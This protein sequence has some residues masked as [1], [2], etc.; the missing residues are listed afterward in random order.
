MTKLSVLAVCHINTIEKNVG[1]ILK[2]VDDI[3]EDL[4]NHSKSKFLT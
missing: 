1:K 2:S 4:F 3:T